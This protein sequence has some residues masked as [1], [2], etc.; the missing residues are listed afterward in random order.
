MKSRARGLRRR[1]FLHRPKPV[2][3]PVGRSRPLRKRYEGPLEERAQAALQDGD[4]VARHQ[5]GA[6]GAR[7][8]ALAPAQEAAIMQPPSG[9]TLV[10]HLAAVSPKD[11]A[12][13]A[14]PRPPGAR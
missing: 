2:A 14:G 8:E 5:G 12:R 9:M 3:Q 7:P 6:P 13:R 11:A 10:M 4:A 1:L